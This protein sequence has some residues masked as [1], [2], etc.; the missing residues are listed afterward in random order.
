MVERGKFITFEGPEG[1]G[2]SSH[3]R[4]TADYIER[5]TGCR[6]CLTREPGGTTTGEAIRRLLQHDSTDAE[7]A[8][9][10][11]VLLFEASRAQIVDEVIRP[12]L[13]NGK[14]VLCD[15][16]L[17]STSAY[18]G[19]GRGFKME[20]IEALNMFATGGLVPDLTFLLDIETEIGMQRIGARG[21][22]DRIESAEIEFHKRLRQGYLDI[23]KRYAERFVVI[24][25]EPSYDI[26]Q[27]KIEK[28]VRE[29][30]HI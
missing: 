7:M 21:R 30:L 25:T 28:I 27:E 24:N 10:T 12:A 16:F 2:K 4:P 13:A 23:A 19:H 18:Q 5:I 3:V 26:V 17:D 29:K 22:K 20:E 1:S 9:R 8:N 15:R 11:E 6:V 14:Y